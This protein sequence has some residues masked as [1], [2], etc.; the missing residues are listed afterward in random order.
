MATLLAAP[1]AVVGD[2]DGHM[3]W[4]IFENELPRPREKGHV[5]LNSNRKV[6]VLYSDLAIKRIESEFIA[7][8]N[9]D[10]WFHC[11]WQH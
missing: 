9:T 2:S 6:R 11:S 3:K 7:V 8:G 10:A 5:K 1:N 4:S